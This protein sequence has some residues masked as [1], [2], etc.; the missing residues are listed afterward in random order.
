MN[1]SDALLASFLCL[2]SIHL[3]LSMDLSW[4]ML[5]GMVLAVLACLRLVTVER[6]T[7]GLTVVMMAGGGF[8][9]SQLLEDIATE[10]S[11]VASY[12]LFAGLL[13]SLLLYLI[14]RFA[15]RDKH[16]SNIAFNRDAQSILIVGLLLLLL[17]PPPENTVLTLGNLSLPGLSIAGLLFAI[18]VPVANRCNGAFMSRML[19]VLPVFLVVPLAVFLLT[20][21]QGP[22]LGSLTNLLP[23]SGGYSRTGFSPYQALNPN[24]FLRPSTRP[25]MRLRADAL[26]SRYL[27]GNRMVRLDDN[28]SWQPSEVRRGFMGANDS[29]ITDSGEFRFPIENN[30]ATM[31]AKGTVTIQALNNDNYIFVS[32]GTQAIT[33]RFAT[34]SKSA[35]DIWVPSFEGNGDRRWQLELGGEARAEPR[36]EEN[37]ALPAF[38][39]DSLQR[40][41]RDFFAGE[42]ELTVNNIVE[43]FKSRDYSLQTSFDPEKPFHDFFL[44]EQA[45]YCFWFATG[46][47]LA[48]RANGIPSRL[49]SGFAVNEQISSN[50]WLVRDRDAHSWVE[51][52]DETG[53]WHTIDPTP[54]SMFAFFGNYQSSTM[55]V[56]YHTLAG[57]WQ[58]LLDIILEDELSTNLVR[59]GGLLILLILF[60]R[61]YRRI[62]VK[63]EKGNSIAKK[64]EK[65][66]Q[67]FLNSAALPNNISWTAHTYA[68]NLPEHWSEQRKAAAREFL[69][70]YSQYRF[71]EAREQSLERVDES[72][73]LFL[74]CSTG[75]GKS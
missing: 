37:L 43:Y 64:W 32:P 35:A 69:F 47:T 34:L 53:L 71:A 74:Q 58:Q 11:W 46:T 41:S 75:S 28:L 5:G 39:D 19:L 62:G 13:I 40:R 42:E 10:N 52:Q 20:L 16:D 48:L 65:L 26:I 14:W 6:P 50:L 1:L 63:R 68:E 67:R 18:L 3:G 51:W 21:T 23:E 25:V 29:V 61:E 27:V 12:A 66:W 56:W 72:F 8:I 54:S 60:V 57:K 59:F 36:T 17:M 30:H 33:G 9:G 70:N 38:W 4:V 31:A 45:A 44:N 55:S 24:A 15:A 22:V 73:S 2:V 49:V 7:W